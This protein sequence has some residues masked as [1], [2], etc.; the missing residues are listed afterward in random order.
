M[1]NYS[2]DPLPPSVNGRS[3][4]AMGTN[5]GKR[6]RGR[7]VFPA[8]PEPRTQA[9]VKPG[10]TKSRPIPEIRQHST[11]PKTGLIGSCLALSAVGGLRHLAN[12]PSVNSGS[13]NIPQTSDLSASPWTASPG[14]ESIRRMLRGLWNTGQSGE[15]APIPPTS[16]DQR[17]KNAVIQGM[18]VS[19]RLPVVTRA[20]AIPEDYADLISLDGDNNRNGSGGSKNGADGC[21]SDS[22]GRFPL[23]VED[24]FIDPPAN[25]RS[26]VGPSSD[27]QRRPWPLPPRPLRRMPR[28]RHLR[29]GSISASPRQRF[30]SSTSS[31]AFSLQ[32]NQS[33]GGFSAGIRSRKASGPVWEE[34]YHLYWPP[35][36][37]TGHR[38]GGIFRRVVEGT[39]RLGRNIVAGRRQRWGRQRA[40]LWR[41]LGREETAAASGSGN[42]AE[43]SINSGEQV[44]DLP[45]GYAG[46]LNT[47][48][49]GRQVFYVPPQGHIVPGFR[50]VG[51]SGRYGNV[52]GRPM[53][54]YDAQSVEAQMILEAARLGMVPA[55]NERM[56]VVNGGSA[57]E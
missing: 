19:R 55:Q 57:R 15:A 28:R 14:L 22:T 8:M 46:V 42:A 38:R 49:R 44:A 1:Q 56:H 24:P 26:T 29:P 32:G 34:F 47:P 5:T 13:N 53:Y 31:S 51:T 27:S 2:E 3:D 11:P 6:Q 35:E 9:S 39:R 48:H 16:G 4:F 7:E 52:S 25:G 10:S 50:S 30:V 37:P 41:R 40:A 33:S 18:P 17:I 36:R 45:A 54:F 23:P 43:A 12:I 20:V 21:V